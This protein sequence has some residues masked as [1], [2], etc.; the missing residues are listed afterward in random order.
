MRCDLVVTHPPLILLTQ[1]W[2]RSR[3]VHHWNHTR[4]LRWEERWEFLELLHHSHSHL[5]S[6]AL[7]AAV[8]DREPHQAEECKRQVQE[9]HSRL[10]G[11]SEADN[12]NQDGSDRQEVQDQ[13]VLDIRSHIVLVANTVRLAEEGSK[14]V[15]LQQGSQL[16]VANMAVGR[17]DLGHRM[18]AR[19]ARD[20]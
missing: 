8:P 3:K 17:E 15:D 5:P 7:G 4:E 12:R 10:E 2:G 1:H 9:V 16:V 14:A 13:A 18:P 19:L 6:W 20:L 11:R